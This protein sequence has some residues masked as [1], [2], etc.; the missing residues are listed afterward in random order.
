M[1]SGVPL[2]VELTIQD[3]AGGCAALAGAD[4]YPGSTDNLA[5]LSLEDDMVQRP[6]SSPQAMDPRTASDSTIPSSLGALP[7]PRTRA[8]CL[9]LSA[10][11]A[12][13]GLS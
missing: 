1:G 6:Y 8:A 11:W 7:S 2:N 9:A 3:A 12:S 13:A 10:R 5:R 4:G